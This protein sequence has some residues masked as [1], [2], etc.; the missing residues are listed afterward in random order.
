MIKDSQER[1]LTLF[2]VFSE[3]ATLNDTRASQ[4][5]SCAFQILIFF[6]VLV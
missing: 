1:F 4:A 6:K 2:Y 3:V 5:A